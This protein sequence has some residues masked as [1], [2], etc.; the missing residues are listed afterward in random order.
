MKMMRVHFMLW[1]VLLLIG[2]GV[3]FVPEYLKNR[4]L[5]AQL[6]NPQKTID[7]LNLQIQLGQLRDEA[8][9][10][11][12][13]ISRQNF[14]LARDHVGEYYTKLKDL[15]DNVQDPNL[16]KSLQDL[17]MTRDAI[18]ADLATATGSALTAWQP[19]VLKTFEATKNVK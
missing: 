18:T 13:E 17:S 7:T 4:E 1:V 19:V 10:A 16:K 9:M 15:S 12:L 6:Q 8:S 11:L 2:L 5:R 3:G 14:G